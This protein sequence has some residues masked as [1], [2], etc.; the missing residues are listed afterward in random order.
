MLLNYRLILKII[1]A[2]LVILG[3]SMIPPIILSFYYSESSIVFIIPAIILI[4]SGLIIL[5]INKPKSLDLKIRDGLLIVAL[6]W[7]IASL[8]GSL[9]FIISGVIPGFA[10]AIFESTSGFT[11]T[12]GSVLSDVESLPNGIIFWR[13]FTH[14]LGGMGILLL[15]IAL[16][17][18]LGISGQRLI[19]AEASGPNIDKFTSKMSDS[20]KL[21]YIM[22]IGMTIVET[23]LLMLGGLDFF[24]SIIHAFGTVSTGG[25]SSYNNSI[26]H[27]DS[28][29]VELVICIFMIMAGTN[30]NLYFVAIRSKFKNIFRDGEYRAYLM[31][32]FGSTIV[33]TIQLLYFGPKNSFLESLRHSFFQAVSILSTTGYTTS[34]FNIW[35]T[36]C[37][38]IIFMLMFIGGSSSSA[39]GAV[40]TV[41]VLVLLKLIRRGIYKRLH[42]TAVVPIKL[43]NK[44]VSSNSVS[45]ITS[46]LFL[47]IS[48]LLVSTLIVSLDQVDIMTAATAAA[49]CLGNI[50]PGFEMVGPMSDYSFFSGPIK[51]Y[52][53]FLMFAGRLEIFTVLLLFTAKFWDPD[54]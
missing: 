16:L 44:N 28:I 29:Y 53:S 20:A 22:Y 35:P 23:V 13:S 51:L 33:L 32:I 30:F 42:P 40:K 4:A 6:C 9:P 5:Y 19:D 7:I 37:K 26:A 1:A 49:A 3:L 38:S 11:T 15:T 34:D 24:D 17:P 31:I 36:A 8:F 43:N 45:N 25:F 39:S 18:S 41:R 21:I 50:G 2:V 54:R 14:W 52:L 12:G 10:D 48:L 47:Y 46:F 27:F